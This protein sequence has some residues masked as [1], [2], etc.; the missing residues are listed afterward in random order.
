ML[1]SPSFSPKEG[2]KSGLLTALRIVPKE[3]TMEGETSCGESGKN[4]CE[5]KLLLRRGEI[6]EDI[7]EARP[8]P[9][10]S[11]FLHDCTA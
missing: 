8:H 11:N 6:E 7:V 5:K 4:S 10:T 1:R 9:G 2:S 3:A